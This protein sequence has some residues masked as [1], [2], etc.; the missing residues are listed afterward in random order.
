MLAS[1]HPLGERARNNRWGLTVAA[2]ILGSW[3][4][5]VAVFSAGGAVG[6][7]V[8]PTGR[9][10]WAAAAAAAVV[11]AAIELRSHRGGRVPGPRRQVNED[12]L[13]RYR[14]WVYGMGFGVQLGAGV[15][16]IVITAATYLALALTLAAGSWRAGLVAGSAY[17]LGRSLPLLLG[18]RVRGPGQ[19]ND[20]HRGLR[21]WAR[22]V[23]LTT[24]TGLVAAAAGLL[25]G[26]VR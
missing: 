4:G 7:L 8:H 16:T 10:P 6:G 13:T 1:I 20:L 3:A 19:L 21:V 9:W 25:I 18:R 22:P 15:L 17:G 24:T 12:W 2:H 26:G 11:C 14:G 5:G 23:Q